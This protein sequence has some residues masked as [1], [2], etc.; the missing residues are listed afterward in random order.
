MTLWLMIWLDLVIL[1]VFS[2]LNDSVML[3]LHKPVQV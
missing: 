2:I 3:R 1:Q